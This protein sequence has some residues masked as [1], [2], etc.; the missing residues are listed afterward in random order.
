[1]NSLVPETPYPVFVYAG[2]LAWTLFAA[3]VG[4]A[5]NSV[6]NSGNMISKIYF[7]RLLIPLAAAGAALVDFAFSL[8]VMIFLM[9]WYEVLPSVN[10]VLL[11]VFVAGTTLAA[12]GFGTL[13]AALV[14]AYRDFRYVIPFTIQ[15]WMFAS[16]VAYP[17]HA[18]PERWHWFTPRIR[19]SA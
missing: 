15:L 18:V 5:S 1:M 2:L 10:L 4:Q 11:P 8:L 7:P 17:L 14:V 3:I 16:P 12:V 6:V 13:S 19:W 9:T